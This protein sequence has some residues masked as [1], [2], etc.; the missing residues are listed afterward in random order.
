MQLSDSV[1]ETIK[2]TPSVLPNWEGLSHP[3]R[4]RLECALS[5]AIEIGIEEEEQIV[6]LNSDASFNP[7]I[8][9]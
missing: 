9:K 7:I 6:L 2:T 1:K 5:R 4:L 3:E 8:F